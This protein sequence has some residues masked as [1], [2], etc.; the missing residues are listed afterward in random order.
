MKIADMTWQDVASYLERDDRCVVPLGS[1]EQHAYI[2]LATDLI[3]AERLAVDVAAPE[4]VPVFPGVAYGVT[5]YFMGYPGTVTL[6]EETHARVVIEIL[7]SLRR[8]GF[9]RVLL[10][11]GHGGNSVTGARVDSWAEEADVDLLWHDW[12]CAPRVRAAVD[13]I[14]DTAS[15]ASWMETFPWTRVEGVPVPGGRKPP[16]DLSGPAAS[17]VGEVRER[18]GDGSLGGWYERPEEQMLAIW[19]IAVEETRALLRDGWTA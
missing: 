9:K 19:D 16:V 2:S 8:H 13:A 7:D 4:G 18:L 1:T 6:S 11:N 12:W 5:P 17:S 14:D 15:H 10:V 3:L